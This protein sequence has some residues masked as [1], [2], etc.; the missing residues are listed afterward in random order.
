MLELQKRGVI[1]RGMVQFGLGPEYVR[2]SVGIPTEN[3]RL[4]EAL[5]DILG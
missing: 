1:V 2:M 4:V 5:K 3:E